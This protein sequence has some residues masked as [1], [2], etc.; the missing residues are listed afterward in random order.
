M[1]TKKMKNKLVYGWGINDVEYAVTK[2]EV[3]DGK[4]KI[5]WTCPYY[6]DWSK[7]IQRCFDEK[8]IA[9]FPTY[10]NCTICEEWK[11]LSN[12]IKW[13]D[14][15]PNRDWQNCV[16]DKDLLISGNKHYSPNTA[17]YVTP[18]LNGFIL[19]SNKSR[20]ELMIGVTTADSKRNPYRSR[21]RNPFNRECEYLGLFESEVAA[22]L[23]WKNKK[24]EHACKLAELQE[25]NRVAK[26]LR[27]MYM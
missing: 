17:V 3:I 15:Q 9:R 21:C 2:Y 22:H 20:G 11:H 14:S 7:M 4:E 10:K 5:T 27:E 26:R 8:R 12:F 6:E 13:V 25:D 16:L 23:A 24:H 1:R 18:N 19:D